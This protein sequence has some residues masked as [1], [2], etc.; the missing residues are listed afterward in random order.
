MSDAAVNF[1]QLELFHDRACAM[2]RR[3]A[4]GQVAFIDA[5]DLC[6]SAALW[7]GLVDRYGDDMVQTTL[8]DAFASAPRRSA[9]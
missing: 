3:V 8:A 6:Y 1:F 9:A 4:A 2:A 5:V 7:A